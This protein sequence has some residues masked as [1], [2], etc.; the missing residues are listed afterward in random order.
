M[1]IKFS[2]YSFIK[3]RDDNWVALGCIRDDVAGDALQYNFSLPLLATEE[4]IQAEVGAM[5]QLASIAKQVL[6]IGVDSHVI[7]RVTSPDVEEAIKTNID[8]ATRLTE[9]SATHE[10]ALMEPEIQE[11][12]MKE[13]AEHEFTNNDSPT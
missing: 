7:W 4:P 11:A 2:A 8:V 5:Y 1:T 12:A 6:P 9:A 3:R 10:I 13:I